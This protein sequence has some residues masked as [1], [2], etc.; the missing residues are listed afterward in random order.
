MA[1]LGGRVPFSPVADLADAL[2]NPFVREVGMRDRIDHP[3]RPQGLDM[4]ACPIKVDGQRMP[5]ARAPALGEHNDLLL[6][7]DR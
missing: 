7:D 1:Y 6:G 3:A 4:L 2:D 5:A